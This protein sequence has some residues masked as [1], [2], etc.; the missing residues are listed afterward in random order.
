MFTAPDFSNFFWR[1]R[2]SGKIYSSKARDYVEVDDANYVAW[3]NAIISTLPPHVSGNLVEIVTPALADEEELKATVLR[4]FPAG[5]M[6]EAV[7]YVPVSVVRE[8]LEA[9]NLWSAVA[10]VLGA[11]MAMAFKVLTLKEGLDPKDAQVIGLLEAVGA[12]P[13][14]ILAP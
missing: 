4:L 9:V 1:V 2:D 11:D 8:R 5:W 7:R 12:D 14:S 13:A 10:A 6:G 3:A